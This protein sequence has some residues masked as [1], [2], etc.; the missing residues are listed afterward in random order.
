MSKF[1]LT[2]ERLYLRSPRINVCFRIVIK[3]L[4]NRKHIEKAIEK[5]CKKHPFLNSFIE[6]DNK[7]EVW[8]V[9]KE[10]WN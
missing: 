4:L 7:N 1:Q 10:D 5:V 3:E 2:G 6:I 9:S 8:L